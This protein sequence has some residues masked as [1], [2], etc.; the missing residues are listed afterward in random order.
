MGHTSP[1]SASKTHRETT[2]RRLPAVSLPCIPTVAAIGQLTVATTVLT[3]QNSPLW[4]PLGATTWP[5]WRDM[6]PDAL[7]LSANDDP[8]LAQAVRSRWKGQ[9]F[10]R[11]R[12]RAPQHHQ[13]PDLGPSIASSSVCWTK[14]DSA[15]HILFWKGRV[16][17]HKY[18]YRKKERFRYCTG[19]GRRPT[20]PPFPWTSSCAA[21]P[22][23]LLVV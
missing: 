8:S 22:L 21:S 17:H 20:A 1:F 3:T 13:C 10:F 7:R 23:Q 16:Q 14:R 5:K 6:A 18:I 15:T 19:L 4:G 11:P 9:F 12:G 2:V